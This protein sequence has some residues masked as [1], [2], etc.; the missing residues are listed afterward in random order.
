MNFLA[1]A[2]GAALGGVLRYSASLALPWDGRSFPWATFLV[3]M[4]GSLAIGIAFA[5]WARPQDET[6][7]LFFISGV[8]GGFTTFSTF[9]LEAVRLASDGRWAKAAILVAAAGSLGPLLAGIGW[10]AASR[11]VR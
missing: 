6:A 3:N 5:L 9:S 2:I 8:L 1:V 11:L 10:L 7:R 4:A